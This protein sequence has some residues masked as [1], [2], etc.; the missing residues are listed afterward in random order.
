MER[1]KCEVSYDG[2]NF[3]GYQVQ[4]NG[5]T[6]QEDVETA[7]KKLHKGKAVRVHASGRTDAGVH[8]KG[9]VIH[10]DTNLTIPIKNWTRALNA[11]L[12]EDICV[13]RS[14][15][16]AENF[17]AR[18]DVVEKEYRYF[19]LNSTQSDVFNRNFTYHVPNHLD[20]EAMEEAC[21]SMVGEHDFTSFCSAR[22]DVKGDKIRTIYHATCYQE[23]DRIIFVIRG[24]GFLYNMVR[25]LV[26]TLI[27]IGKHDRPVSDI[28]RIIDA[29]NRENA[30]K[31]APAQGLFLWKV[32]YNEE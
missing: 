28:R 11:V 5:R 18:Y 7:L 29:K 31:T 30:G 23:G 20:I 32:Q 17:H 3:S 9:Q 13:I 2:T 26:G 14:E 4:P 16:V 19:I 8:A 27:E 15:N 21:E 25:I 22:S 6:I 12:P 10:F 24:N 1:I